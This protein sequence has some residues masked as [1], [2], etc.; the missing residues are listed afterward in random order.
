MWS[1]ILLGG[2]TA[3][4]LVWGIWDLVEARHRAKAKPEDFKRWTSRAS[5]YKDGVFLVLLGVVDMLAAIDSHIAV[6]ALEAQ[7]QPRH[8]T[9]EQA[10]KFRKVLVEPAPNEPPEHQLNLVPEPVEILVNTNAS[11]REHAEQ[12][13]FATDLLN[14]FQG[15]GWPAKIHEVQYGA[16][17][18]NH[19]GL[20]VSG[21][22]RRGHV[23]IVSGAVV[24]AFQ[25]AGL[26]ADWQ[27]FGDAAPLTIMVY[28]RP[29]P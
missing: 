25:V 4:L 21:G 19:T 15:C 11:E 28:R 24:G 14:A 16:N 7:L 23:S 13:G 12:L 10:A 22:A 9:A 2:S 20:S 8:F 5:N 6:A 17:D 26:Y 27:G 29:P 1:T 3:L 18:V